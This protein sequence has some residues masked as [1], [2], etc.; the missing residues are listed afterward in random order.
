MTYA[1]LG[2]TSIF[3][4]CIVM[5]VNSKCSHSFPAV[6]VVGGCSATT[7]YVGS[8]IAAATISGGSASGKCAGVKHGYLMKCSSRGAIQSFYGKREIFI[9]RAYFCGKKNLGIITNIDSFLDGNYAHTAN[10]VNIPC[11]VV[12]WLLSWS[13]LFTRDMRRI[14]TA[15]VTLNRMIPSTAERPVTADV[16]SRAVA[17]VSVNNNV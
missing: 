10:P 14:H 7:S 4:C 9:Y 16:L 12:M 13:F 1:A 8:V 6:E 2:A 15:N 3:F 11:V 17:V 5:G